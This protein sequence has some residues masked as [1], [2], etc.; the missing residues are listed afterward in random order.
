MD[1]AARR[2][3]CLCFVELCPRHPMWKVLK[4]QRKYI[5][6]NDS[7]HRGMV[8]KLKSMHTVGSVAL[9]SG[10]H[11]YQA[12]TRSHDTAVTY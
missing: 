7:M 6:R 2:A 11:N 1:G 12:D 4:L 10:M 9:V 5:L 8:G 3:L